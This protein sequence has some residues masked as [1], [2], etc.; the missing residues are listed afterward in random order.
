MKHISVIVF[1]SML[2]ASQAVMADINIHVNKPAN[3]VVNVNVN[4]GFKNAK[5]N[6]LDNVSAHIKVLNVFRDCVQ[7]A[8]RSAEIQNCRDKKNKRMNALSKL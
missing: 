4:A 5:K 6:T 8:K 1:S 3:H 2:F 7:S